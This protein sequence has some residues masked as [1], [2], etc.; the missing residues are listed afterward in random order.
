MKKI[1][2]VIILILIFTTHLTVFAQD[3]PFISKKPA[4]RNEEYIQY[5]HFIQGFLGK[6]SVLQHKLNHRLSELAR[7]IKDKNSPKPIFVIIFVTFI[8]GMIHA[9][10]P[11]HGKTIIFSY[12]LANR[13]DVKKGII[14]GSLIGFLH[15]GSA[16]IV[17]LILYFIIKQS[18]LHSFE[19]SSRIIKLSSYGLITLIGLFLL[20]KAL[21]DIRSKEDSE[22]RSVHGVENNKSI[23]PFSIAVGMIPC[24]GVTIL[25]LFSLSMSILVIGIILTLFMALG[26][27]TTISLVGVLTILTKQGVSKF[28]FR[29]SK[30]R[31]I[32][33]TAMSIIG[34]LL[35]LFLGVLLFIGTM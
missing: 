24:P 20:I 14:V 10:G 18:F 32:F 5:P 33:Q 7:E 15:A 12:F 26:M 11:G 28:V 6:I 9:L 3:N 17:V 23:I 16:L 31:A 19:D 8:Y 27:A 35:I 29:K 1:F 30:M 25:L 13:A 21:I 2:I 34:S 4:K 22:E